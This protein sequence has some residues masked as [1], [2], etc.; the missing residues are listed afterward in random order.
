MSMKLRQ[1][2]II[3]VIAW[4]PYLMAAAVSW[5]AGFE[6]TPANSDQVSQ[7]DDRIRELK[8][9]VRDHAEVEHRWGAG[10]PDSTG[11]H[12]EGSAVAWYESS[13]PTSNTAGDALTGT[14]TYGTDDA[15][16]LCKDSD[17]GISYIWEGAAWDEL[18]EGL[19]GTITLANTPRF[20]TTA[21]AG[22]LFNPAAFHIRNI[23]AD[24]TLDSSCLS[25]GSFITTDIATQVFGDAGV[26]CFTTGTVDFS[27]RSTTSRALVIAQMNPTLSSNAEC[28]MGIYRDALA[29][30]VG[31]LVTLQADAT[32]TGDINAPLVTFAYVTGITAATHEFAVHVE[33]ISGS[34]VCEPAA[35]P[36][37]GYFMFID[38]GPE[39]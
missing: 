37:G 15:G 25:A 1:L 27:T 20:T 24:S 21:S 13:C 11:R 33:R 3:M 8:E 14:A 30:Q 39:V 22:D 38:L 6:A 19:S 9:T 18:V 4:S 34:G 23:I 28:I 5:T 31:V 10:A 16:R 36:D 2:L 29:N 12:R 35:D 17:D 7:G 32:N 26:A